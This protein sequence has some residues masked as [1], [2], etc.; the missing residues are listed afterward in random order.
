MYNMIITTIQY[1]SAIQNNAPVDFS[2]TAAV[3]VSDDTC[4]LSNELVVEYSPGILSRTSYNPFSEMESV[5][6]VSRLVQHTSF[7]PIV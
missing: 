2:Q 7:C 5:S 3:F 6:C 1:A 4:L